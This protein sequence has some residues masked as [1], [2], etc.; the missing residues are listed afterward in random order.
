MV[1]SISGWKGGTAK[2]VDDEKVDIYVA[3]MRPSRE[4]DTIRE[5]SL[6][7]CTAVT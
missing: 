3:H 7:K 2:R 4:H 6:L 5:P 1:D